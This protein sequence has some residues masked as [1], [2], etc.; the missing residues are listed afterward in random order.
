ME[1]GMSFWGY[2][3]AFW[4]V[5]FVCEC[6]P[7]PRWLSRLRWRY[8]DWRLAAMIR[9]RSRGQLDHVP[10][11]IVV[12]AYCAASKREK[13]ANGIEPSELDLQVLRDCEAEV[14]EWK[15]RQR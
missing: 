10:D 2:L 11:R 4:L 7:I 3:L 6:T 1:I 14:A 12:S 9:S 8:L 13:W 5:L 15:G